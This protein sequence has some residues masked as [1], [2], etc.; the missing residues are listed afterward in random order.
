MFKPTVAVP[1]WF[2]RI[3][4]GNSGVVRLPVPESPAV[5]ILQAEPVNE[6][7]EVWGQSRDSV[8]V[9]STFAC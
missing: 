3:I 8:L 5:V 6:L 4:A 7:G 2:R 9:L 1:D